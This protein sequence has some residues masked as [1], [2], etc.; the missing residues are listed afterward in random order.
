M[1]AMRKRVLDD[2]NLTGGFKA[3]R[4]AIARSLGVD[5]GDNRIRWE[6]R[7]VRSET[8]GTVVVI[9]AT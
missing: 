7:Q 2:D 5:D 1:I 9:Q 4:D 3:L 6:C 8:T